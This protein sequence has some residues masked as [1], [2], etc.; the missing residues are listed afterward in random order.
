M[1]KLPKVADEE[2]YRVSQKWSLSRTEDVKETARK[3]KNVEENVE[4]AACIY[5]E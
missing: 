4:V 3:M 1:Q 5:A 2:I